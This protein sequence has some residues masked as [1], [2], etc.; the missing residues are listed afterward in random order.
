MITITINYYYHITITWHY[1]III[2]TII[3][4]I[5]IIISIIII[6]IITM[7]IM[8]QG[9]REAAGGMMRSDNFRPS[10]VSPATLRSVSWAQPPSFPITTLYDIWYYIYIYII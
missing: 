6:I 5:I 7:I 1:I 10:L 3:I 2:I 8:N 4:I 9:L